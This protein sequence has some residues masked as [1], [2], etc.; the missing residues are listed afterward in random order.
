MQEVKIIMGDMEARVL[1]FLSGS[2]EAVE[3]RGRRITR[4]AAREATSLWVAHLVRVD[5]LGLFSTLAEQLASETEGEAQ[6]LGLS[7]DEHEL[8]VSHML[9][10]HVRNG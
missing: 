10:W 2:F 9:L 1:Q 4:L 6:S 5:G 7:P 3:S 8:E